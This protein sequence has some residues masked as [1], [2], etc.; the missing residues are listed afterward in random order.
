[1]EIL[2]GLVVIIVLLA[3]SAIVSYNGFVKLRNQIEEAYSTMDVYLKKRYEMIPNLVE[4]VK[5]YSIHE[6]E[7]LER[8]VQA[9]NMAINARSVEERGQNENILSGAIKS[10]FALSEGYPELKANENYLDLQNNL[11]TLEDEISQSR[12]Y[13]NG[14]V[15]VMN[16]KVE[17]FPSNLFAK[18]FGFNRYPYFMAE[19]YERQNVEIRFN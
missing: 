3:I 11:R 7:T 17:I 10:L 5:Q 18:I 6:K 9:R 14:V 15:K 1:M 8:I 2:I 19:E 12:K 4:V 16:N 13:Y